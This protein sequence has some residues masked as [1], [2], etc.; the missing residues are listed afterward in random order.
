MGFLTGGATIAT[1]KREFAYS[2]DPD[3]VVP[4]ELVKCGWI[5][6]ESVT[7]RS[8]A[9]TVR[10]RALG[11][12]EWTKIRDVAKKEGDATAGHVA[13]HWCV[14]RAGKHTK[15]SEIVAWVDRLAVQNEVALD[16]L[17]RTIVALTRGTDPA[18]I[19]AEARTALGY[20]APEPSE[21][22]AEVADA[23]GPKSDG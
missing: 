1:S 19:Y 3:V 22:P 4:P 20:E 21:T 23:G 18:S 13:A 11:P 2:E 8:G 5:P 16:L 9:D 14:E 17:G 12:K 10:L 6:L 7:A 15:S